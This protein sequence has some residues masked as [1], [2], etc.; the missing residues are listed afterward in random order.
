MR[1]DILA[2]R[3]NNVGRLRSVAGPI[4]STP[5][6]TGTHGALQRRPREK[7][8]ETRSRASHKLCLW[9]GRSASHNRHIV[10]ARSFPPNA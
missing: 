10:G 7:R 3:H 4:A 9:V 8:T 6:G 1:I 2:E 5:N